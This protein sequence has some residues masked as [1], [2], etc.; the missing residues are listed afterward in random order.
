[1][2]RAFD[3]HQS[4]ALIEGMIAERDAIHPGIE[5]F[6]GDGLGDA[7]PASGVLAI[8]HDEIERQL[9]SQNRDVLGNGGAAGAADDVAD[10][11]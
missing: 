10:E 4:F 3:E 1:M 7:K 9:P 5:E 11:Q 2:R 6:L 8:G